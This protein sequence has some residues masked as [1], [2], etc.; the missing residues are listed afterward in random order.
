MSTAT[1]GMVRFQENFWLGYENYFR[2]PIIQATRLGA[3]WPGSCIS[4]QV[5]VLLIMVI[6]GL[7]TSNLEVDSDFDSFLKTDV[8]SSLKYEAFKAA[9]KNRPV[10]TVRRL[11]TVYETVYEIK[12]LYIVYELLSADDDKK[13]PHI[14][15]LLQ[16]RALTDISDFERGLIA[17]P[18]WGRI[19]GKGGPDNV[20]FCNPGITMPGYV[21]PTMVMDS[22]GVKPTKFVLDGQG[23][24]PLPSRTTWE[25]LSKNS[26]QKLVLPDNVKHLEVPPNPPTVVKYLRS[27]FRF[28][29]PVG[30]S[31]QTSAQR[32]TLADEAKKEWGKFVTEKLFPVLT[33]DR[34][35]DIF[36]IHYDGSDLKEL[37]IKEALTSD[38]FLCFGSVSLV[39]AYLLFH[40][41]SCLLTFA[42]LFFTLSAVPLAYVWCGWLTG[43]NTVNFTSFLSIF[44]VVGFGC[45]VI[46]VYTDFWQESKEYFDDGSMGDRLIWTFTRA[47]RASFVTTGTTALSFFANLASVIR[48]LRQFGFFMGLCVMLAWALLSLLYAPL[49]VLDERIG[50]FR[51]CSRE[52]GKTRQRFLGKWTEH[53]HMWRRVYLSVPG[54]LLLT[55]AILT[56]FL[57]KVGEEQPNLF[58]K[59]HNRNYGVDVIDKHFKE[60][61]Q[62]VFGSNSLATPGDVVVCSAENFTAASAAC[63]LF[64]CEVVNAAAVSSQSDDTCKCYREFTPIGQSCKKFAAVSQRFVLS[65][66]MK[67]RFLNFEPSLTTALINFLTDPVLKLNA[68]GHTL[69][70]HDMP[71]SMVQQL[72][73]SG[74]ATPYK[75]VSTDIALGRKENDSMSSCGWKE[76]CLCGSV[77]RCDMS[78]AYSYYG[79]VSLPAAAGRR[80]SQPNP[81]FV[82]TV[83]V[84]KQIKIR[85]IW[86]ILANT[87]TLWLG[88]RAEK[89][90]WSY[91]TTFEISVPSTQ[92]NIFYF[93][94][95]LA[96]NTT[97]SLRVARRWCWMI[98][99]R[100]WLKN[101]NQRFP[102]PSYQFDSLAKKFISEQSAYTDTPGNKY[103]WMVDGRIRG[104]YISVDCDVSKNSEDSKLLDEKKKWDQHLAIYN[105]AALFSGKG[106][107]HVSESWVRA[108]ATEEVII[109]A[110]VTLVILLLLAFLGMV[111]FTWS[112]ALSFIVVLAT[113]AVIAG[114]AFFLVVILQWEMGMIEVIALVYFIGYAVTYSLHITH[115][116]AHVEEHIKNAHSISETDLAPV[117]QV[118]PT[119]TG[120]GPLTAGA[121]VGPLESDMAAGESILAQD[122]ETIRFHRSHFAIRS[123]GGATLGS[124]ATTAGAAFFLCFA[125]LTIFQRL[126]S[127]CLIVTILSILVALGP[128]P[129][130]LL[131]CG[132]VRP[133]E[134]WHEYM[135]I[136]SGFSE[137]LGL[138]KFMEE[139]SKTDSALTDERYATDPNPYGQGVGKYQQGS[140]PRR[141][142]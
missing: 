22:A 64:W 135:A 50:W 107:F 33:K 63:N 51:F 78:S 25:L 80:M 39:L 4:I 76:V 121:G 26:F 45:D 36:R 132:P 92:R 6:I 96:K 47:G 72:W 30:T 98:N 1:D 70:I 112:I 19:C 101:Q 17:L 62:T 127:M 27:A 103:I 15:S 136:F 114:L 48:A 57:V 32:K 66:A 71:A 91:L 133:G 142:E 141:R 44:L 43:T 46:F 140:P 11:A 94:Q 116:Y 93:C 77:R 117:R 13:N 69:N 14:N 113:I 87:Q 35:S 18:E 61:S 5:L 34:H 40:T 68:T 119:G 21:L 115:K 102:V 82:A 97:V 23:W 124:A 86:G 138:S 58:P 42:G 3:E 120:R 8:K 2:K 24:D 65:E 134:G 111:L 67:N 125:T 128:L 88:E 122:Y 137:R 81:N 7:A 99:F 95:N 131:C 89:D 12:N 60:I 59:D 20:R 104:M 126:G 83:K 100:D 129:A 105:E 84:S 75:M 130:F 110:V 90:M 56:I 28:K 123:M 37:E 79:E 38:M 108:E 16:E 139:M 49:C 31:Q 29:F 10:A 109:S 52:A 74:T 54:F 41:R 55:G 53:V 73:E 106:A 118:S 9:D 85:V